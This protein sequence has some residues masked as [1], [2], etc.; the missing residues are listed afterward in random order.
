MDKPNISNGE[1]VLNPDTVKQYEE[2]KR[3][4]T[5]LTD[6]GPCPYCSNPEG[7]DACPIHPNPT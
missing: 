4:R 6:D 5:H 1:H 3:I 2:A 7:W